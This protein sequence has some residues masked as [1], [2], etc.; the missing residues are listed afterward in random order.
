MTS[1]ILFM[2]E[3][4]RWCL[5][6][7]DFP[8]HRLQDCSFLALFCVL[9]EAERGLW[10]F[11]QCVSFIKTCNWSWCIRWPIEYQSSATP[12]VI[13]NPDDRVRSNIK[14]RYT[15]NSDQSLRSINRGSRCDDNSCWCW[16][17]WHPQQRSQRQFFA[18][19]KST[20]A[21]AWEWP[22]LDAW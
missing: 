13:P 1:L 6:F 16:R 2:F 4:W 19:G 8:L 17:F 15:N 11:Q 9:S 10:Y 7:V 3:L 14:V 12:F 22:H 5:C 21:V 20:E 18:H